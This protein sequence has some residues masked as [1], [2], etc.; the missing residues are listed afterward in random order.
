MTVEDD[1]VFKST[2]DEPEEHVA[3]IPPIGGLGD[4]EGAGI[5]VHRAG[6]PIWDHR[7]DHRIRFSR[8]MAPA[9]ATGAVI[10]APLLMT[11]W[12][13]I[14]PVGRRTVSTFEGTDRLEVHPVDVR[15]VAARGPTSTWRVGTSWACP[16]RREGEAEKEQDRGRLGASVRASK[17]NGQ[18]RLKSSDC[19]FGPRPAVK[20]S[21]RRPDP[22][23]PAA[24][25]GRSPREFHGR[26][27]PL[28]NSE[29]ARASSFRFEA[30]TIAQR[31]Y[32]RI[33]ELRV[34]RNRSNSRPSRRR[35]IRPTIPA[36]AFP[37]ST[38]N[39]APGGPLLAPDDLR[40]ERVSQSPALRSAWRAAAP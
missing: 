21:S 15:D 2:F 31:L 35:S 7:G 24:P 22:R 40:L 12:G 20:R 28:R 37:D 34:D 27:G 8:A 23:L 32:H 6:D 38:Y 1:D 13:S 30:D 4:R 11:P 5:G 3:D 39:E 18:L 25:R 14:V 26:P 36:S 33:V 19:E 10:S 16:D 17:R 9:M 29:K